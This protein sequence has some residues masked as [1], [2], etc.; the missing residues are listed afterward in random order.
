MFED[1]KAAGF[2]PVD[3]RSGYLPTG[4]GAYVEFR[5]EKVAFFVRQLPAGQD[6][7]RLPPPGRDSRPVQRL[8]RPW[9]RRCTPRN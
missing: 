1:L 6:S 2:E 5:D 4:L 8:C 7:V 9:P 3:L